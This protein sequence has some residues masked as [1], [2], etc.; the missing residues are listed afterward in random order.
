MPACL[1]QKHSPTYMGERLRKRNPRDEETRHAFRGLPKQ[2]AGGERGE[3]VCYVQALLN[4]LREQ[5][6][7][8]SASVHFSSQD[9]H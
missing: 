4:P 9:G 3:H 6:K 1:R 2:A 8:G 5:V 7:A